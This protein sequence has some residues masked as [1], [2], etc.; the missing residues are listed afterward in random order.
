MTT[1][2]LILHVPGGGLS[3]VIWTDLFQTVLMVI[4]AGIL[5][6]FRYHNQCQGGNSHGFQVL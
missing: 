6:V 2:L 3:A 5:M 4:G 1:F